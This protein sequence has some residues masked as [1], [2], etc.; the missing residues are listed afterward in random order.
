MVGITY[1]VCWWH[2][3]D[4]IMQSNEGPV[5]LMISVKTTLQIGVALV[6]F[7]AATLGADGVTNWCRLEVH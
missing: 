6:F 1:L 5:S 4:L 3:H 7:F 2:R